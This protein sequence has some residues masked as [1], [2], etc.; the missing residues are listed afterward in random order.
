[1]TMVADL[2]EIGANTTAVLSAAQLAGGGG[3][4]RR[5]RRLATH[6]DNI[7][8][9][10]R[11]CTSPT[12]HLGHPSRPPDSRHGFDIRTASRSGS[13]ARSDIRTASRAGSTARS[14]IRTASRS[15]STTGSDIGTMSRSGST[16]R[17]DIG[18]ARRS[19][20]TARSDIRTARRSGSTAR[21]DIRTARRSGSTA[22]SDIRTVSRSGS[23]TRSDIRTASRSGSA[24]GV[25]SEQKCCVVR[26]VLYYQTCESF[27]QRL[28]L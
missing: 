21:S 1:M 8:A 19:G 27:R 26:P 16:A 2:P 14:D 4:P 15:G 24:C 13:T 20:S 23:T 28:R 25:I 6:F 3:R 9:P 5:D 12:A 22:R 7:T 17:S 18:T 11:Y 10:I